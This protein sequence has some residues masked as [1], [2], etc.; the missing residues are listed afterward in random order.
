MFALRYI[1]IPHFSALIIRKTMKRLER[2]GGILE[3]MIS[4][5]LP[6]HIAKKVVR[7]NATKHTLYFPNHASITFG[8]LDTPMDRFE[9]QGQEYQFI[10]VDELPEL[11]IPEGEADPWL[12]LRS[13]LRRP[14]CEQH[15]QI[16]AGCVM[17]EKAGALAHVPLHIL[18]TGNPGGVSHNYVS[19]RFLTDE[20]KRAMLDGDTDRVFYRTIETS[21]GPQKIAFIP[22][23]IKDNPAIDLNEYSMTLAHL[24]DVTRRRLLNGDWT[25]VSDGLIA[26]EDVMEAELDQDGNIILLNADGTEMARWPEAD[27]YRFATCDPAGTGKDRAET[28]KG[29][30][31]SHTVII[32]FDMAPAHVGPYLVIRHVLR[33]QVNFPELCNRL[34]ETHEEWQT[35]KL[36]I[37]NEKL[38]QAA[39]DSL[40]DKIPIETVPTKGQDKL[41]RAAPLLRKFERHE[42]FFVRRQPW[43][44]KTFSEI[45]RWKGLK[46]DD[47]DVVDALAYGAIESE[48]KGKGLWPGKLFQLCF[49]EFPTGFT[50][51]AIW[52]HA[53]EPDKNG[54]MV[55]GLFAAGVCGD[56]AVYCDAIIGPWSATECLE[57]LVA[58]CR[59]FGVDPDVVAC[60]GKYSDLVSNRIYHAIVKG[61]V[62]KT[63]V[64]MALDESKHL[65]R[66]ESDIGE[67]LSEGRIKFRKDSPGA[68][69]MVN[70]LRSYPHSLELETFH[71]LTMSLVALSQCE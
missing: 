65:D 31:H 19:T 49:R 45:T 16:T 71:G 18:G 54:N 29:R 8:F 6:D 41:T 59:P 13:R 37:E 25:V 55:G 68:L 30:N 48:G 58:F 62:V 4:N 20:A 38:G 2:S 9:Y 21:E 5:W 61:N 56:G 50:K 46:E 22:S 47:E 17:C 69:R 10:G 15:K 39:V 35:E 44:D 27:S 51:T 63:P 70:R 3:R 7:Y 43:S 1:H 57:E 32:V 60:G 36:R 28:A 24:S 34:E 40:A 64:L 33:E 67:L 66:A 12:F 23:L 53:G 42:V 11:I 52:L 26:P 14:K